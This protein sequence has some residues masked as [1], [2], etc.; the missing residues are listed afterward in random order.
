VF[1]EDL[2]EGQVGPR[3]QIFFHGFSL[4]FANLDKIG[5][6]LHRQDK[7]SVFL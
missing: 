4:F 6:I 3:V 1:A 7:E 5:E 2:L